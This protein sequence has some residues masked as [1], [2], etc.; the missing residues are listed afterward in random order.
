[1]PPIAKNWQIGPGG[2]H[3]KNLRPKICQTGRRTN[4]RADVVGYVEL[5]PRRLRARTATDLR[6]RINQEQREEGR[7]TFTSE[8]TLATKS[9][10]R[11]RYCRSFSDGFTNAGQQFF[12]IDRLLKKAD[13]P[14]GC[15][16][17]L[18][19]FRITT[20]DY[21]DGYMLPFIEAP[22]P[23]HDQ[24]SV[25]G[26]AP[27]MRHIRWKTD[28]QQNKVGSFAAYQADGRAAVGR[29]RYVVAAA[30]QLHRQRLQDD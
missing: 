20:A 1:M 3:Y 28:V 18:E 29:G 30:L 15:R 27:T 10:R 22:Q 8:C 6:E 12:V 5:L 19:F 21:H 13:R 14:G 4:L 11:G 17:T 25:P 9:R 24:E 23:I 26:N 2:R 7:R 16:A